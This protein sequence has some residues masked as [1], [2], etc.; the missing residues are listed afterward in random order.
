[1]GDTLVVPELDRLAR[2]VPDT[3]DIGVSLTACGVKLP[4]GG[5]LYD[6]ARRTA[7]A[8]DWSRCVTSSSPREPAPHWP[9][10]LGDRESE[11]RRR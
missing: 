8:S 1:V 5:T 10:E 11:M 4:L 9:I 6:P 7:P 3:R 2:F